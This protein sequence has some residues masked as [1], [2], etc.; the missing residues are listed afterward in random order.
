MAA[1]LAAATRGPSAGMASR[2]ME[3]VEP[4][5]GVAAEMGR[6][7]PME[8]VVVVAVVKIPVRTPKAFLDRT[9]VIVVISVV[10]RRPAGRWARRSFA[11]RAT[12]QHN[13]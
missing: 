4:L 13:A 8:I 11:I 5:G 9:I 6:F 1:A 2:H 12:R 7:T 3:G 10:I